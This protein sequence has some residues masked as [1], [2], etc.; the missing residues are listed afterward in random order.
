MPTQEDAAPSSENT[1]RVSQRRSQFLSSGMPDTPPI[2]TKIA[3]V[4][5]DK[6]IKDRFDSDNELEP[7]FDTVEYER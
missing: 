4:M 7:F 2:A 6:D 3:H 1:R 5:D